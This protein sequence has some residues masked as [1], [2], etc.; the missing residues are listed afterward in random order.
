MDSLQSSEHFD[1]TFMVFSL[2][3]SLQNRA[4]EKEKNTLRYHRVVFLVYT[5]SLP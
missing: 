1:L 5:L 3:R 2:R 4:L